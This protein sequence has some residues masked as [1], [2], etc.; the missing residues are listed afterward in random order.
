MSFVT[1]GVVAF[2]NLDEH[3]LYQGKSTG[4]FSV[5]VT[6]DEAEASKL[7]DKGV[8]VKTYQPEEGEARKQRKFSSKYDVSV[9]DIDGNRA[10]NRIPFGSTVRL[11][12][13]DGPAHPEHGVPTYLNKVRVIELAEVEDAEVDN[14]EF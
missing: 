1:T 10:S 5:V 2:C 11:L 13:A 14:S 3:E 12:W 7:S 4:R 8:K 9:L 6:L